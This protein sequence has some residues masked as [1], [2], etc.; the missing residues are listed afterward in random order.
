[1]ARRKPRSAGSTGARGGGRA[2]MTA[3]GT[4]G[5]TAPT[6]PSRRQ[7]GTM[8]VH[9]RLLETSPSYR[10]RQVALERAFR[11]R[12][13]AGAR[14]RETI[15]T[16]PVVVH[17]VYKTKAQKI[18]RSQARSQIAVLN[19][20]YAAKNADR[21][22][23]PAVWKGLVTDAKIRFALAKTDPQGNATTGVTYTQTPVDEFYDDDAVK[24]NS[25][26]GK[27]AWPSA[28]YLNIWVC[29]LAGGLLGYAQ[30]PGGPAATDGI[31][32]LHTAF[33]TKGTA[34][35]PFNK[36]R[37]TTHEVG[38]WLNLRHIWGDTEDCSGGD[39]V[40]DTPNAETANYGTP[41]YP[42]ISCANGP[43]GDM[44][45]NYM[46]YVDD[47]AMFMFTAQQVERMNSCLE[48]VRTTIGRP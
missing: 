6:P 42:S 35:P 9:N 22:K 38:H 4:G 13:V 36:G 5:A 26:Y 8:A 10:A 18:T 27:D 25:Q 33:G 20:D 7:C 15:L 34:A 32:V 47:E 46:D 19:K 2:R 29:Q 41:V 12:L 23:V 28:R 31:V 44:F 11:S 14:R 48:T 30:F 43:H 17:V 39:F 45:M 37:T 16:I 21:T 1:M 3:G 24:F 40:N